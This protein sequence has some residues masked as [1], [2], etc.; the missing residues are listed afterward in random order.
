MMD[1]VSLFSIRGRKRTSV[2]M[3][4]HTWHDLRRLGLMEM[5]TELYSLIDCSSAN[6]AKV[7]KNTLDH[8]FQGHGLAGTGCTATLYRFLWQRLKEAIYFISLS[9]I[10]LKTAGGVTM[11]VRTHIIFAWKCYSYVCKSWQELLVITT[12]NTSTSTADI[13]QDLWCMAIH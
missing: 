9:I 7:A 3:I 8:L 12:Y 2:S 6:N 4:L 11:S 5:T 10:P 13:L 1:V